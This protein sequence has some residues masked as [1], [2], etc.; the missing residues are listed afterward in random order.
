MVRHLLILIIFTFSLV[1]CGGTDTKSQST[2]TSSINNELISPTFQE[3]I[4]SKTP[5]LT[6]T[7]ELRVSAGD[8]SLFNGDYQLARQEYQNAYSASNDEIVRASALWGLGRVEYLSGYFDQ[9]LQYLSELITNYPGTKYANLG[10][11]VM[12][13]SYDALHR[14]SE[15]ASA[16]SQFLSTNPGVIDSYILEVRGDSLANNGDFSDALVAYQE[17]LKNQRAGETFTLE[18]KI[19]KMFSSIGDTVSSLA[20]YNDIAT[21]ATNDYLRAQMD[22]LIGQTFLNQGQAEEAYPYF[23]DTVSKYPIAYDS[24]SALVS[25]VDANI[26]VDDFER[27]LV[28]YFAGQYGVALDVFNRFLLNH[29]EH[30]GSV[31]HFLALINR[32]NGE[33]QQ[34]IDYWTDLIGNYPDNRYWESAW[35][36]RAYTL[37]G[38]LEDF[39]GAAESLLTYATK[40]PENSNAPYYLNSAARIQE[41]GGFLEDAANTWQK[42]VYDYST[43]DLVP[44]ALFNAGVCLYRLAD[45]NRSIVIFQKGLILSNLATDQSRSYFWIGKTQQALRDF[46]SAQNSFQLAASLDPTGYYSERARSIILGNP[47]FDYHQT[48]DLSVDF[49]SERAEAEA[50]IRITF[51][52][53][54]ETNLSG[55]DSI[56]QDNRIIRGTKLWELWLFDLAR[57]EFDDFRISVAEIPIDS[58]RLTN[59]MV[60]LGLYRVAIDSSRQLLRL[61][62]LQTYTQM[63]TAPRFFNH[64][65]Y[66]LYFK[67]LVVQNSEEFKFDPLFIFCLITQES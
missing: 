55:F 64:I 62:G 22:F 58:Y 46:N 5:T 53:P 34:A 40:F 21:R 24:Y 31:L 14:F 29:P 66:G 2:L 23:L 9:S 8:A 11:F 15:A 17:S 30:D 45:Y 36:E 10:Y 44:D 26:P 19:A 18:I 6:P 50:W 37:W 61:A 67:D 41:R 47:I 63:L 49:D 59:Y 39:N 13:Q 57:L 25:L 56:A 4:S 51:G 52:L 12:A 7:P 28:D 16:Y 1:G 42:L 60:E 20:I 43:S 48:Y 3:S 38:Y 35:D 32:A 54:P 65:N 27:G 33:Y